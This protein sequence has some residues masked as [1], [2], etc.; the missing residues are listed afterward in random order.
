MS[1][2]I[3]L[4]FIERFADIAVWQTHRPSISK[5]KAVPFS[6]SYWAR[7]WTGTL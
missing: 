1:D 3:E 6:K 7:V 2:Q 4:V 5:T